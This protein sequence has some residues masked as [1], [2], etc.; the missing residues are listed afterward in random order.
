LKLR[1]KGKEDKMKYRMTFEQEPDEQAN[2]VKEKETKLQANDVWRFGEIRETLWGK[3]PPVQ[4]HPEIWDFSGIR[5][6]LWGK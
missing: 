1:N 2:E 6:T 4:P 3:V 5:K